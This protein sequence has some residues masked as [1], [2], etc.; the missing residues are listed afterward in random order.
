[1]LRYL[2]KFD[3]VYIYFLVINIDITE[4]TKQLTSIITTPKDANRRRPIILDGLN[5]GYA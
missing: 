5:I 4:P 3:I 2:L 1:M